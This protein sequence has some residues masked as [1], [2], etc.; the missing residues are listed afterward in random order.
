M[1]GKTGIARLALTHAGAGHPGRPVGRRRTCSA[2]YGKLLKP[3]PRK[4]VTVVA[5]PPGGPRRPL[6][7]PAG[8]R[9]AARGHR[10]RHGR[11]H[12]PARAR[13]AARSRPRSATT[14]ASRSRRARRG[15]AETTRPTPSC[16]DGGPGDA[17][18]AAHAGCAATARRGAGRRC[19]GHHV[20]GRAG[21]RRLRRDGLGPRR[22]G[23]AGRSPTSTATR[24]TCPGSSCPHGVTASSD[25]RAVL[26]GADVVAVAIPSQS[27]R[28]TLD[29]AGAT[30]WPGHAVAV[31]LM[32]GVELSHRPAHER[33]RR[34]V[35][36]HPGGPDRR[37]LRA[38][39]GARDRPPAADR[40][41]RGLD[42]RGD[43]RSSSRGRA[44]P[45]TSGRTRTTTSSA[46][47]CAGP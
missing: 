30:P 31:S 22:E 44:R 5:G 43:R 6:R 38:Q 41:G 8:H 45:R 47:S 32:K 39:P 20:R 35:A 17:R 2:R 40:D 9:D 23:R 15:S 18:P 1:V 16:R 33:G 3:F 25:A 29:A 28:A 37:R 34:R 46:S 10:A 42:Q 13:S 7:P 14:C 4:M 19:L 12:G 11:D 24:P 27:A 26:A 21:R 36:R